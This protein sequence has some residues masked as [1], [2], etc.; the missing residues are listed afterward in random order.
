[1]TTRTRTLSG[2]IAVCALLGSAALFGA[3]CNNAGQGALSG[4]ALGAG[5]GAIIGSFFGAAGTGA[6]VGAVGG[7]LGG[8]VIGDQNDRRAHHHRHRGHTWNDYRCRDW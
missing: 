5:A 1:M 7:A 3:G 4:G 6:A 8:G 2:R